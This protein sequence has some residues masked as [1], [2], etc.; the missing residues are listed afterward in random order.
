MNKQPYFLSIDLG[1]MSCKVAIFNDSGELI[2]LAKSETPIY[3]P[4]PTHVEANPGDW[5]EIVKK[6][7]N[8]VL[9]DAQ[10]SSDQIVCIGL[11]GLMHA[12]IPVDISGNVV[13]RAML[14]MDQR[15]KPQCEWMATNFGEK[16]H[17]YTG[18][19]PST[20]TSA[21]KLL[22]IKQ[23]KPEVIEK[24][25]KFLLAKDY[26]RFKLTG[27]FATDVTDSGGTSLL[28]RKTQNWS[29]EILEE[30]IGVPKEKMPL[31]R[32]STDIAGGVTPQAAAETTL[33]EGTPVI[34]GSSD[35]YATLVGANIY[36]QHRV[37]LYMGTA[38]WMC[39]S[40][41]SE[42]ENPGDEEYDVVRTRWLGATA[43]LGATVKWYKDVIGL[44]EVMQA[45]KM[46]IDPYILISAEA[47]KSEPGAGGIIFLPHMMGER[48]IRPNPDAKGVF[49]GL[50]L[51]HQ[52]CH[53]IRAI[54]EGNAYLIRHLLDES[55]RMEE[56][57]AFGWES[58]RK[59]QGVGLY[60]GFSER[61]RATGEIFTVGGG[62][63]SPLWRQI[64]ADVTGKPVLA[65]QI[66]ESASLGV[67]ILASVGIGAFK[68]VRETAK[69][70]VKIGDR[71]E[72]NSEHAEQYEDNYRLYRELDATLQKFW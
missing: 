4:Q 30:V 58:R 37:C 67:A 26:I 42:A 64:I 12:L 48:A 19:Y 63:K 46:K 16:I 7:I 57:V 61:K 1:T 20:T 15:C 36:A 34:V 51:A 45:E 62:A 35:V 53:L 22:W 6:L 59:P 5:W 50:T 65:P 54:L 31:I 24:T 68:S 55:G 11:C 38:A 39:M 18:R 69:G 43:T 40:L 28:D 60:R 25:H 70:W 49:F 56:I 66:L 8:Q 27:E 14:W 9:A 17:Q 41:H 52:R 44:A 21:A 3:Y 29:G 72:P 32:Q 71:Q 47:E 23:N 33:T 2:S 10:I 13:D